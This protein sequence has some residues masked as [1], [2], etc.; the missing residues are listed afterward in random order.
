VPR[1]R[2]RLTGR[3]GGETESTPDES[4]I[5]VESSITT[6]EPIKPPE[7]PEAAVWELGA[8]QQA[9]LDCRA[10]I[11]QCRAEL[12]QVNARADDLESTLTTALSSL[13]EEIRD[14][15]QTE[16]AHRETRQASWWEKAL[17]GHHHNSPST[18]R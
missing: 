9:L 8:T 12:E 6:V 16:E 2:F 14:S 7:T 3:K 17:G 15:E 10:E 1:L 5:V 4:P 18:P 13:R 11:S